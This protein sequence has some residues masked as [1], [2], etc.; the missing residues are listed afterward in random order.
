M[1][2]AFY[3]LLEWEKN[4]LISRSQEFEYPEDLTGGP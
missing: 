1:K 4:Y 3:D 2:T